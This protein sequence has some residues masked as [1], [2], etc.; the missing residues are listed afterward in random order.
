MKKILSLVLVIC[1]LFI[2]LTSCSVRT[3]FKLVGEKSDIISVDVIEA[4]Y[5]KEKDTFTQH[6]IMNIKEV[7]SFLK[8]IKKIK[9]T[10]PFSRFISSYY[11]YSLLG[12]K[13]S[14]LNGSHEF[15]D[16]ADRVKY[17]Y[18]NGYESFESE[19]SLEHEAFY[20]VLFE[21]LS[22][23]NDC[24]FHYMGDKKAITSISIVQN[25][26]DEKS[27]KDEVIILRE[28]EDIETFLAELENIEYTYEYDYNAS[29]WRYSGETVLRISYAGDKHEYFNHNNRMQSMYKERGYYQAYMGTFNEE[30]FNAL[31][32]KYIK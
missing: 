19:Y 12:F 6:H 20:S 31:I 7:D 18:E 22:S 8:K 10:A 2:S 23:V 13:I 16:A 4:V 17:T 9:Y 28:I 15:F 5:V 21:Y 30:Q 32:N 25:F 11:E 29:S 26:Y 24:E 3:R 14:Y 27:E 1:T